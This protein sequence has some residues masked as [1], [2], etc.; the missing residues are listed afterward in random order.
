MCSKRHFVINIYTFLMIAVFSIFYSLYSYAADNN[1]RISTVR[2]TVSDYLKN[3]ELD[4]SNQIPSISESDFTIPDNNQ[5]EITS[6][7]WLGNDVLNIGGT[8]NVEVYLTALEKEKSNDYYTYYYFNGNYDSNNVHV[9]GGKFVSARTEGNYALRVVISL[10][11][12]KGIY[13]A[14]IS[15]E[16]KAAALGLASWTVP[17]NT[18]GYYKVSLFRDGVKT[19]N[20]I[21]DQSSINLYPYMTKPGSYYF[22]VSTVPYTA[23]QKNGK[24]SGT[25]SSGNIDINRESVSDGTGQYQDSKYLLY[26]NTVL[27]GSELNGGTA[28]NSGYYSNGNAYTVYN[29]STGQTTTLPVNDTGSTGGTNS[30]NGSGL[31]GNWYKEGNYW[32]FKTSNGAIVCDN[33]LMWKNAYYRFDS[34]G[35]MLTGFYDKDNYCTYFLSKSGALKTGWV[36]YNNAWYYMNPQVGEYYG[37][38]YKNAVVNIGDKSYYFDPEGKM[39][40]GWVIIKDDSGTEQYYYFYP[41]TAETGS[42][43]GHM[44]KGTTILDGFTLAA[45]G[46]WIR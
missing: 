10:N 17:A 28:G 3:L 33:W 24:E 27:D 37:L 5:Y 2:I 40:T 30:G 6:V 21:T 25:V 9:N 39:R 18:S 45:D 19:A 44:A 34:E 35:R 29:S 1:V 36:L 23:M 22:E 42:N 41:E 32:Y 26:S 14:P 15:P 4:G 38:M 16:W 31:T 13:E 8:P 20:I 43:Y 11:G 12:L 7:T 46:H